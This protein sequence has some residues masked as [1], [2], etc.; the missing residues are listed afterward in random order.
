MGIGDQ[1][2]KL[3]ELR[4]QG[5][6]SEEEF[7]LAK[8]KVLAE[9]ATDIHEGRLSDISLQN[10]IMQLDRAWELERE[11]YMVTGRYGSRHIP[12]KGSS[13]FGGIIVAVFGAF[14]T[15]MAFSITG[16]GAFGIVSLLFPLFGVLFI[17]FGIGTSIFAFSK[18]SQYEQ[19]F[20]NYQRQRQQLLSRQRSAG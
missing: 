20:D 17:L 18:A 11:N 16:A 3:D 9:P 12:T 2:H 10:E 1:L 19:A 5:T 7:L 14:W 4:R 8:Q 15:V 6:I 13:L